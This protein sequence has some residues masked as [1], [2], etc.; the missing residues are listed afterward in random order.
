MRLWKIIHAMRVNFGFL[1][2]GLLI[3]EGTL[4]FP[5]MF[6]FPPASLLLVFLGL[7]TI[8]L[9]IPA[10]GLLYMIDHSLARFLGI[11]VP[12]LEGDDPRLS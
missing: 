6:I 5:L 4:A 8:A 3:L 7:G 12:P 9:S 1:I 11:E 2:L 10:Q